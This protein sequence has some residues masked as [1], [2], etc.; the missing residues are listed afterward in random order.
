MTTQ[1]SKVRAHIEAGKVIT[2]V[3]AMAVYGISRLSSCIED[4]RNYGVLID[5]VMKRDEA[6]KQYGE[7]RL[8]KPIEVGSVVQVKPGHAWGLPCWVRSSRGAIVVDRHPDDRSSVLVEFVRGLNRTKEWM[9]TKELV[10]A[11]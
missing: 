2:P 6:G 4:L 5:C 1:V 11:A 10:N 3:T 8:R 7:Y 9:L